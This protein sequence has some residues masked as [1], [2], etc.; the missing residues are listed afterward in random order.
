VFWFNLQDWEEYW[1]IVR[2]N[3]ERKPSF[4]AYR[5]MV[6]Q[7]EGKRAVGTLGEGAVV[8]ARQGRGAR[9]DDPVV[10]SWS[11][12]DDGSVP[13]FARKLPSKAEVKPLAEPPAPTKRA[14]A[15]LKPPPLPT[16]RA[17]WHEQDC[18][19]RFAVAVALAQP[20]ASPSPLVIPADK[21]P[22][23]LDDEQEFHVHE[24]PGGARLVAERDLDG[25]LVFIMPSAAAATTRVF[26][27]YPSEGRTVVYMQP[28]D[29]LSNRMIELSIPGGKY[30]A[31]LELFDRYLHRTGEV[32]GIFSASYQD[33]AGGWPRTDASARVVEQKSLNGPVLKQHRSRITFGKEECEYEFTVTLYGDLPRVSYEG[34]W[35]SPGKGATKQVNLGDSF[36][37]GTVVTGMYGGATLPSAG[38][39]YGPACVIRP[40]DHPTV[41]AVMVSNSGRLNTPGWATRAVVGAGLLYQTSF[42]ATVSAEYFWYEKIPDGDLSQVAREHYLRCAFPPAV[43]VGP[44]EARP[45]AR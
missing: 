23:G 34:K 27:V 24:E 26:Y 20:T 1:G 7:L 32:S 21:L 30:I 22:V 17:T 3:F 36:P 4:D 9:P 37:A 25:N 28:P 40:S 6:K 45:A 8:F 39:G 10:V 35:I 2:Q 5:I 12:Q 19:A 31:S 14:R 33:T 38:V 42:P 16:R 29:A 41:T 13:T 18:P 43:T 15:E 11:P 44:V